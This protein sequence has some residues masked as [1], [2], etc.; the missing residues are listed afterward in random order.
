[1]NL[2]LAFTVEYRDAWEFKREWTKESEQKAPELRAKFYKVREAVEMSS[3]VIDEFLQEAVTMRQFNHPNVLP[4]IG[5]SV[6]QKN[7]CLL[8]PLMPLG[9]LRNYLLKHRKVCFGFL[10][11]C[12]CCQRLDHK[13][14]FHNVLQALD[15]P[16]LVAFGL[17]VAKGMQHVE[18]KG[19]IHRDLAARNCLQ[20]FQFQKELN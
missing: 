12:S 14:Y 19:F 5:V 8:M 10:A 3:I 11:V 16:H 4:L 15:V 13:V 17:S 7:P 9:N 20:V 2:F 1:M 18:E 6:H